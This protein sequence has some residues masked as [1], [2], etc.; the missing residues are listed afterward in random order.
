MIFTEIGVDLIEDEIGRM[1]SNPFLLD[2]VKKALR[3]S[4]MEVILNAEGD[5]GTGIDEKRMPGGH[6]FPR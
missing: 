2:L 5:E 4:V 3:S 1:E 6:S